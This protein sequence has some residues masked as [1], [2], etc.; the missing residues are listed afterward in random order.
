[1]WLALATLNDGSD[2]VGV[3]TAAGIVCII[4]TATIK[5]H[6]D[7]IIHTFDEKVERCIF[8]DA[9]YYIKEHHYIIY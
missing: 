1:M 4:A 8:Q 5:L 3:G 7:R 9:I 2:K 6:S